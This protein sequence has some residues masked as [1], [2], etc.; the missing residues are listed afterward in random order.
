[1]HTLS[2]SPFSFILTL[3]LVRFFG[4]NSSTGTNLDQD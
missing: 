3:G 1:M 2:G 4:I